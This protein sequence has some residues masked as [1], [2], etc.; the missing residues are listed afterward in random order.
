V[1]IGTNDGKND[2]LTTI[3][4]LKQIVEELYFRNPKMHI[5]LA[6]LNTPWVCFVNNS[7]APLIVEL[8]I[9][10]PR[11][12]LTSVDMASGWVNCPQEPGT[13]TFDW[14]HP[15]EL[16]QK[17]MAKNWYQAF[18]SI[19]DNQKPTFISNTKVMAQTD[20]TATIAWS[21]ATDNKYIAGYEVLVDGTKVNWHKPGCGN[22]GKQCFALLK[23]THLQLTQLKKG[24]TYT[25]ELIVWDFANNSQKSEKLTVTIN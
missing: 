17:T 25:I 13:M 20:T 21:P 3:Q 22:K 12:K 11:M 15:N 10:Y 8:Q 14:V 7:I 23:D 9:R 16:G 18:N 6:K 1:H 4:S 24:N 19:G 5:F 2:S